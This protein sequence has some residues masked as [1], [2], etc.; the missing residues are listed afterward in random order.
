[1]GGGGGQGKAGGG[2]SGES[3]FPGEEQILSMKK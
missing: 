2:G 3:L 1:M